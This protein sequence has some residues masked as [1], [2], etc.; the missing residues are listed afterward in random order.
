MVLENA[1]ITLWQQTTFHLVGWI[2]VTV[3]H[4]SITSVSEAE[5]ITSFQICLFQNCLTCH[6]SGFL[7]FHST[8]QTHSSKCCSPSVSLLHPLLTLLRPPWFSTLLWIPVFCPLHCTGLIFTLLPL[9]SFPHLPANQP[10]YFWAKL[11][12]CFSQQLHLPNQFLSTLLVV[13]SSRLPVTHAKPTVYGATCDVTCWSGSMNSSMLQVY[14]EKEKKALPI[15][16]CFSA[17]QAAAWE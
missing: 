10:L 8:H 11:C 14:V 5:S 3:M 7:S 9:L 4:R 1:W 13:S 2:K 16:I 12:R 17:P 6:Q 15:A